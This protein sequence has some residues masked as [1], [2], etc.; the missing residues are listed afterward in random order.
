MR[1]LNPE[2]LLLEGGVLLA[3]SADPGVVLDVPDEVLRQLE[4]NAELEPKA[5]WQPLPHEVV[6]MALRE[7]SD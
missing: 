6:Q 1:S 4:A 7:R 5:F 3:A 2:T